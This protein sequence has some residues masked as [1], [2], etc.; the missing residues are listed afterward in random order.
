MQV[1][2]H[3]RAGIACVQNLDGLIV[4][5]SE[6]IA[7]SVINPHDPSTEWLPTAARPIAAIFAMSLVMLGA[8]FYF[9]RRNPRGHPGAWRFVRDTVWF[10]LVVSVASGFWFDDRRQAAII[11]AAQPHSEADWSLVVEP[12]ERP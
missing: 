11:A 10:L 2:T 5:E 8:P 4:S 1:F 3:N 9:T 12:L 6:P 7:V